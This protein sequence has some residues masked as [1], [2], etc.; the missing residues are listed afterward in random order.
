[1]MAVA[2]QEAFR[3]DQRPVFYVNVD[4]DEVTRIGQTGRSEPLKADMKV[5]D[6]LESHCYAVE[7]AQRPQVM[8]DDR[9]LCARLIDHV[10]S[11]GLGLGRLNRLAASEDARQR[12]RARMSGEDRD[13]QSLA[14]MIDLFR[15]ARRLSLDGNTL[16]FPNEASRQFVNG[17]WLELHVYQVLSNLRG[18]KRG[19]SDVAMGVAI[20][21]PDGRTRNELDVAC[22]LRNTL[23]IV[24]CKT[25]NLAQDGASGDDKATESIYKMEALSKIGGLRTKAM[26]VDY[27]GALSASAANRDRAKAA[28]IAIAAS[29]QLRDLQGL[30]RRVWVGGRAS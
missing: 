24:E 9:D 4:T 18:E 6:L 21:H 25:A 22:L 14:R 27:R 12:L 17:G 20:R 5:Q 2:A 29:D 26:I 7:S 11:D 8:A 19:I 3:S 28:G 10:G 16:V 1:M 15:D 30:I 23:H 13:S